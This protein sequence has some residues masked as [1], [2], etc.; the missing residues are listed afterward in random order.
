MNYSKQ[1]EIIIDTLTKNAVHPTA[2]KLYE[3]IKREHP[4][5]KI[6]I[7]TVYRNLNKLS[8]AGKVKRINALEDSE[9]F[10]NNTHEHYHFMCNKCKQIF[11]IEADIAPDLVKK[12]F[13][14]TGFLVTDYDI[15]FNGICKSCQKK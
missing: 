7:A 2:E 8:S 1:R 14:K 11:D 12:I 5:S 15:V 4:E 6:G 10:D 9:H 13:D 3:I